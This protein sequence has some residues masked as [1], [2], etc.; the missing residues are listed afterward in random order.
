MLMSALLAGAFSLLLANVLV[1]GPEGTYP[2][3]AAALAAAQPGD[4]IEVRGGTHP[5]GLVVDRAVHLVGVG[6]P[7]L[8]GGGRGTVITLAAP[9]TTLRGFV[10]RGSGTDLNASDAGIAVRAPN[11]VVEGNRVE[12]ALFGIS[13]D[14]AAGSVIR[15][16]TIRGKPLPP[17]ER[18][19]GIRL[20]S[21][22]DVLL[23]G[24]RVEAARDCVIWYSSNLRM[25]RNTIEAGRYGLHFMFD[26][27]AE[28]V[29]NILR[30]N[31]VGAY[32]M[33]SR[34]VLLRGNLLASNRGPSGFGLGLKD[35]DDLV[36]E[37]NWLV[38][39]RVG[40]YLDNS[41]RELS[42]VGEYR[43]NVFAFNDIALALLPAVERNVF[44]DNIFQDNQQQISVQGGGT[45][46]GNRWS[47][48]G[49]GNFW[50]DYGGFDADGDGIGDMPYRAEAL[51]GELMDR[52]PT[53]RL[54]QYSLAAG[55]VEFA[56]RAFPILRPAPKLV[57]EAP[58][59][60]P[61][62][63]PSP[64]GQAPVD[65]RPSLGLAAGLL[66][67][68]SS[69]LGL[70]RTRPPER[71]AVPR[72]E[73]AGATLRVENLTKRFGRLTVVDGLSFKVQPGEAVALWGPNGA[74]KTTALKCV[75]GLLPCQGH[76][77]VAERDALRD[78]KR[79]RQA[80]G[81]VP[82]EVAFH[83]DLTVG[84]TLA[85]Y[86]SLKRAP[87]A[88]S[89][90]LLTE[91]GLAE[92]L[93]KPIGALSGGLRQRLALAVALVSDPPLLLLD[94]PTS[95]LD[96]AG[97]ELVLQ[98]LSG[99]RRRGTAILFASHRLEEV[100]ALADRVLVLE[101]GRL[102][103]ACS[104]GDLPHRLGLRLSL[105]LRVSSEQREA[106]V[107]V[108]RESGLQPSPNGSAIRLQVLPA[109]KVLPIRLLER[110]GIDVLDFAIEDSEPARGAGGV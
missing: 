16:N 55:A 50:S 87:A 101:R 30:G 27:N 84:E 60:A 47:A 21:S 100:E 7:V 109:E 43:A 1:V 31:S 9:G 67:L 28:V 82:Q 49:R 68:A 39:N 15:G 71:A 41:P 42:S 110:A 10:I 23:E 76:I 80:V 20:W 77:T 29:G 46:R 106:A 63:V 69:V 97:R 13:L 85:F 18:G 79:A 70:G 36:V 93:H 65:P 52:Q 44:H 107:L 95:N 83:D 26:D 6:D 66:A 37:G 96:A 54:F 19:D 103:F 45:L 24:N 104:P 53:L 11:V 89:D 99:L 57:D 34:G 12:D 51:F 64:P 14:S 32:L 22:P 75:L 56:A 73:P 72:V 59:V 81:Y 2:S 88:R 94:E 92:H 17:A 8:E 86:A 108:L 4:T 25:Y 48:A 58:L 78:G 91:L 61:P 3:L 90:D 74:G 105:K 102:A 33:Y 38:D 35:V 40:A 62:P 5:G 98:L